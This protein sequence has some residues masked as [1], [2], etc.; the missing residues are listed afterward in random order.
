MSSGPRARGLPGRPSRLREAAGPNGRPCRIAVILPSSR[1]PAA[2]AAAIVAV[3]AW[4]SFA[5]FSLTADG[6]GRAALVPIDLWHL[7]LALIV[8]VFAGAAAWRPGRA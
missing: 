4:L 6:Q 3:A 1:L 5:S 8:G 7:A 2:C